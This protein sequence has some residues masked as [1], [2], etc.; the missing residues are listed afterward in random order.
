MKAETDG[1]SARPFLS[2][3]LSPLLQTVISHFTLLYC[4]RSQSHSKCQLATL[5]QVSLSISSEQHTSLMRLLAEAGAKIDQFSQK[6]YQD[7]GYNVGEQFDKL[8]TDL[9]GRFEKNGKTTLE[10]H[11]RVCSL[12]SSPP[13]LA[14]CSH[15][16]SSGTLLCLCWPCG[17]HL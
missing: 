17:P 10:D 8:R 2:L 7:I 6:T 16:S 5:V 3:L 15:T 11:F 1:H 12:L 9:N 13:Y 4:A 14:L